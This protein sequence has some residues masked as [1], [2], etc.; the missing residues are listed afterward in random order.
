[1]LKKM[2]TR[3]EVRR[4]QGLKAIYHELLFLFPILIHL[5]QLVP[6]VCGLQIQGFH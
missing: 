5:A 4:P 3:N 2:G 1:M 6:L